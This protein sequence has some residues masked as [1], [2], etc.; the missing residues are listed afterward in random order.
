MEL[1]HLR[2]FVA[3]AE[4]L[5]FSRAAERLHVAQ[6]PLS[7]QIRRLE[8]ELGVRLLERT[9]RRVQLTDAGRTVLEEARRTLSQAERVVQAARGAAEGSAGILRVGFSSSAP[10]T[11]LPA[12]LR[13]FRARYP[14]VVLAL[15]ER[16]TEEQVGMLSAGA[17]DAG[18]LRRPIADAPESL[19]VTTIL[20]EPLI[21][22]VP[23]D[24]PL[25]RRASI[26]VRSL[27]GEPFVFFPR[28]AAPGLYDE[29]M[30]LC[31]RN[32]FTPRVAQEAV[33]MQTIVSLVS[34]GLGVAIVP[35]SMRHLHREH[36]SYR[37]LG[38]SRIMTEL[39]VAWDR[40]NPSRAL[41]VFL[42]SV[43]KSGQRKGSPS[44]RVSSN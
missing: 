27:A 39:G 13:A 20:R 21:L 26:T 22:A 40:N 15:F 12:I 42:Q 35:A 9:R 11:M 14:G 3:V 29:I 36:V 5:H 41:Q 23:R 37:P 43:E 19:A 28:Q 30:A 33:Q 4:E 17:L 34:A 32:G 7:Q 38:A 18:F 44:A 2:Y 8:E 25:R 31:R 16:S 6:P 1:R 24:H 10:Y